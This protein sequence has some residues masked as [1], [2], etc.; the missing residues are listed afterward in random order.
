MLEKYGKVNY[1][2]EIEER[3]KYIFVIF[4]KMCLYLKKLFEFRMF[5][6][7]Y[8]KNMIFKIKE[9]L[10]FFNECD[11]VIMVIL[12]EIRFIIFIKFYCYYKFIKLIRIKI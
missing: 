2:R 11:R 1:L 3:V 5:F 6:F 8:Y 7:Y 9:K 12:F 4:V 10:N